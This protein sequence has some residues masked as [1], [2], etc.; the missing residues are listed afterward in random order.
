MAKSKNA[1][2]QT[3]VQ[4]SGAGQEL[5]R[6]IFDSLKEETDK[7]LKTVGVRTENGKI[8]NMQDFFK[9]KN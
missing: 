9:K 2:S 8:I 4:L 3:L 5:F 1:L 7:V 6:S